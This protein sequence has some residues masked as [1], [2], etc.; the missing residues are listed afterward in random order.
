MGK[1]MRK[2]GYVY[3]KTS[4]EIPDKVPNEDPATTNQIQYIKKLAPNININGGLETLG[5]WQ[6]SSIIDQ[7]KKQQVQLEF[8]I[9]SGKIKRRGKFKWIILMFIIIFLLYLIIKFGR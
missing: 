7:I 9:A 4:I 2:G 5:K 6:A 1:D 3:R 8:D